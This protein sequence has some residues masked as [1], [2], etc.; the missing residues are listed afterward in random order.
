MTALSEKIL[1]RKDRG[2]R[3][4]NGSDRAT[5]RGF[6]LPSGKAAAAAERGCRLYTWARAA[7]HHTGQ[8]LNF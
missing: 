6:R 1:S 2:K 4:G 7:L 3:E 5:T 8:L